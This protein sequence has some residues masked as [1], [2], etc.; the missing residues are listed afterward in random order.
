M[1]PYPEW[2]APSSPDS[3]TPRPPA[4]LLVDFGRHRIRLAAAGAHMPVHLV[5]ALIELRNR[6]ELKHLPQFVTEFR[7]VPAVLSGHAP[8]PRS[9]SETHI[10]PPWTDV[11]PFQRPA[12]SACLQS[13]AKTTNRTSMEA[14]HKIWMQASLPEIHRKPRKFL[15][16]G[17]HPRISV[18]TQK[19][20]APRWKE[21][22]PGS[23]SARRLHWRIRPCQ[24]RAAWPCP[25][26]AR[27]HIVRTGEG[28]SGGII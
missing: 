15:R 4:S 24:R 11:I 14:S 13:Q 18:N 27:S 26:P 7:T 19:A 9:G 6:I 5:R 23:S 16:G 17:R 12:K 10:L 3:G 21:L 8:R 28:S 2:R 20:L 25:F 1:F 22:S